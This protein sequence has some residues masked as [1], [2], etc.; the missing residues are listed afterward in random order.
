LNRLELDLFGLEIDVVVENGTA[1]DLDGHEVLEDLE[2]DFRHF[3]RRP[4]PAGPAPAPRAKGRIELVLHG[5]DLDRTTLPVLKSVGLTPR[6]YFYADG[7][8]LYADYFAKAFTAFHC[9]ARRMDVYTRKPAMAYEIAYLFILSQVGIHLDAVGMRRVHGLGISYRGKGILLLLPS[10][11]G[12]STL[13]FKLLR[14]PHVRMLSEDSPVLDRKLG[15]HAFP[16]RIGIDP[17]EIGE[18][19]APE[20][21]RTIERMEF[22]AKTV[23]DIACF[24][25]RIET[26]AVRLERI[27]IGRRFLGDH[28]AVRA[29]GRLR[30]FKALLTKMV[31]GIGLYQGLEYLMHRG[32]LSALALTPTF[33]RRL[34]FAVKLC[35]RTK[36]GFVELGGDVERNVKTI[37]AFLEAEF[38]GHE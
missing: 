36:L 24:A 15:M 13:G 37:E 10:G 30:G 35:L 5:E 9:N 25:D 29:A 22:P 14:N 12:K 38:G 26:E 19:V 23:I 11:G 33:L 18:T 31:L 4:G 6:N 34:A 28:A 17:A 7:D 27:L 21:V 32:V 16:T 8:T 20:H 1:A 3:T 2:R